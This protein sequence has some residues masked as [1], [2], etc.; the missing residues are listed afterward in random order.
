[1]QNESQNIA[2]KKQEGQVF[3]KAGFIEAWGRGFSKVMNGFKAAG[4]P[5][6]TIEERDGGLVV[7]IPRKPQSE[8]GTQLGGQTGGQTRTKA[9]LKT[10]ELV[11]QAIKD[12]PNITRET[13]K[14]RVGKAAS[15]IQSCIEALKEQNRIEREGSA[16]YGGRWKI[17][18]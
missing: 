18:K 8:T 16:T 14:K 11:Y 3:N 12:D 5:M 17:I 13:L 9:S 2:Y 1:M 7:N 6:P 15:V 4:L 10:I